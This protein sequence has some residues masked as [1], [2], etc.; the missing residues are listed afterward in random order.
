MLEELEDHSRQK[1]S[2]LEDFV[3]KS[4]NITEK[5]VSV[6]IIEDEGILEFILN[7]SVYYT[8]AKSLEA[9]IILKW[10][11]KSLH[12][13]N[14][15]NNDAEVLLDL[16]IRL[17]YLLFLNYKNVSLNNLKSLEI[18]LVP[19]FKTLFSRLSTPE[20]RELIEIFENKNSTISGY[21]IPNS[22]TK[23][24]DAVFE[25]GINDGVN[26]KTHVVLFS[27]EEAI[28]SLKNND[29]FKIISNKLTKALLN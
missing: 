8:S 27:L 18:S 3:F 5:I 9:F 7:D 4:L 21:L 6:G 17:S 24:I 20:Y 10:N 2:V 14:K 12:S 13:E 29:F 19:V 16:K 22:K 28:Q 26:Y 15:E 23:N 25:L 1:Y 11:E